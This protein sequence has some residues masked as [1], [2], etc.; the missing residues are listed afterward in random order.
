MAV[1]KTIYGSSPPRSKGREQINLKTVDS[2]FT[3]KLARCESFCGGHCRLGNR[4][5]QSGRTSVR[6]LISQQ[7]L[8]ARAQIF[9]LKHMERC[10][11]TGTG[12]EREFDVH[13]SDTIVATKRAVMVNAHLEWW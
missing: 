9:A 4:A 1:N 7:Q 10:V 8:N 3:G 6:V 13:R 5:A 12:Q 2:L 11:G